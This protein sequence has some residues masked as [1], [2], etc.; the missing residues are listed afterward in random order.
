MHSL[1]YYIIIYYA[2]WIPYLEIAD[3]KLNQLLLH[4]PSPEIVYTSRQTV[5]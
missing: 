2:L 4:I 5:I 3:T 1:I